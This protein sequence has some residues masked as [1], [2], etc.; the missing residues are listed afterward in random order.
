[1]IENGAEGRRSFSIA[2]FLWIGLNRICLS[3]SLLTKSIQ[4][5]FRRKFL[6]TGKT[7]DLRIEERK[8]NVKERV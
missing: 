1:M 3:R 8:K 2:P 6:K 7:M 4:K 5:R